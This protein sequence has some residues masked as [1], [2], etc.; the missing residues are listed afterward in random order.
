MKI[1]VKKTQEIEMDIEFPL[2]IKK[3]DS[4]YLFREIDGKIKHCTI[5]KTPSG[6]YFVSI[7]TELEYNPIEKTNKSVGIDLGLK[8]L[9]LAFYGAGTSPAERAMI[10]DLKEKHG[11]HWPAQ[12]LESRGLMPEAREWRMIKE[13]MV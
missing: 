3:N 6:K 10:K 11:D 2:Y 13:R 12:W 9:E 4:Y 8:D 1:K 7:L 5:S